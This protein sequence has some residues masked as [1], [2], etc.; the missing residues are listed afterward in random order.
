MLKFHSAE[1]PTIEKINKLKK[2][3][4]K[5][6]ELK[7]RLTFLFPLNEKRQNALEALE[8][9]EITDLKKIEEIL[10]SDD[11]IER[12][13]G[14]YA[15]GNSLFVDKNVSEKLIKILDGMYK[16]FSPYRIV[17]KIGDLVARVKMNILVASRQEK[18][19][20]E[21]KLIMEKGFSSEKLAAVEA[22]YL[23]G[24]ANEGLEFLSKTDFSANDWTREEIA[25][26]L[27]IFGE[28]ALPLL[29]KL[30]VDKSENTRIKA[31]K[32][33]AGI[34][35]NSGEEKAFPFLEKMAEYDD[36]RVRKNIVASLSGV[37]KTFLP[38]IEKLKNDKNEYVRNAAMESERKKLFRREPHSW[39]FGSRKS[40]FTTISTK[41]AAE[42]I[43]NLQHI[44][45]GCEQKFKD[46]F[47]GLVVV[48]SLDKGYFDIDSESD[49][50]AVILAKDYEVAEYVYDEGIFV[51]MCRGIMIAKAKEKGGKL[52]DGYVNIND[53][54]DDEE[55]AFLFY[56]LF[57][58]NREKLL[59]LQKKILNNVDE[60]KWDEIRKCILGAQT[61]LFKA[62]K[63]FNMNEDKL[64]RIK[65]F[66][67]LLRVPPSLA[68]TRDIVNSKKG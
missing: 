2:E 26:G 22:L 5:Y 9:G 39:L 32:S 29:E 52:C 13:A 60:K 56:G 12:E 10:A 55:S 45:R 28:K 46:R 19:L 47:V 36:W 25:E 15:L 67:A 51:D 6:P 42:R 40:L 50:D 65:Q 43:I 16:E 58:G 8:S 11:F 62:A 63:R 68:E 7:P 64:D 21:I 57:F 23:G 24:M 3:I 33:K 34:L 17:G 37:G 4:E 54:L 14:F 1:K 30:M 31:I 27:E 41:E 53:E 20:P 49:L 38:L 18:S 61:K 59:D 35:I 66:S 44:V 48:G